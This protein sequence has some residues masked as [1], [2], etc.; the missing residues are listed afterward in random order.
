MKPLIISVFTPFDIANASFLDPLGPPNAR[1]SGNGTNERNMIFRTVIANTDTEVPYTASG[2]LVANVTGKGS[3]AWPVDVTIPTGGAV[4]FQGK[5]PG[6]MNGLCVLDT[7]GLP[8]GPVDLDVALVVGT[9][10]VAR[11]ICPLVING[12]DLASGGQEHPPMPE[13]PAQELVQKEAR[14]VVVTT[15]IAALTTEAETIK[16]R[17]AKLKTFLS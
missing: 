14:L 15:N 13:T 6:V 3:V 9:E 16:P 17:I 2:S 5:A 11:V 8:D 7:L 12:Q 4:I 10:T 1:L